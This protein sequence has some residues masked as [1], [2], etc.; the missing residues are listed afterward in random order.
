M[1]RVSADINTLLLSADKAAARANLDLEPGTDVLAFVSA[2][3]QAEM[4]AGTESAL[5]TMSPLRVAQA[6]AAFGTAFLLYQFGD[7]G[8]GYPI[9]F[10]V[11][12][13]SLAIA[14]AVDF[15]IRK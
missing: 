12:S 4:E 11:S 3:S 5:R 9:L 8:I 1:P 15:V 10:I 13:T 7:G 14:F 6:I 2:A